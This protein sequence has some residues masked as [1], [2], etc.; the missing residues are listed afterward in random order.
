[1]VCFSRYL[2]HSLF[3]SVLVKYV[4]GVNGLLVVLKN[5]N[6]MAKIQ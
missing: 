5:K 1:M 6:H 4:S 3:V 2:A